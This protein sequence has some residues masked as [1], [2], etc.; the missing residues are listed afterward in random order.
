[1]RGRNVVLSG[2]GAVGYTVEVQVDG[3]VVGRI[4]ITSSTGAWTF[5]LPALAPGYREISTVN[6][7]SEVDRSAPSAP[8][9]VVIVAA[10]PLDFT[11]VGDTAITTWRRARNE[12]RVKTRRSSSGAWTTRTIAGRY[13]AIADYDDDGVSDV[14]AVGVRDGN[15]EWNVE[16]STTGKAVNV[17]V[18]AA[19]DTLVSGCNFAANKGASFAVFKSETRA[20]HFKSLGDSST[21]EVVLSGLGSCNVIGCGDTDGDGVDELLFTTRGA[22]NRTRVVGYD[23][24]GQRR[25]ES[26]YNSFVRGFVVDRP[27][28]TVPLVAVIGGTERRGRHVKITTMAGSFAFPRFFVERGA[29]IGNGTFTTETNEQVS[30]IFWADRKNRM[31]SRR[32]L[33]RGAETTEL[34]KLPRGFSLVRPQG[35][36]RTTKSER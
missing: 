27:N 19:G 23:T 18:G 32:L 15:L 11:G 33:S 36:V 21:R 13:P 20:L 4:P 7:A 22:D 29:T 6:V 14:A 35:I 16:L 1:V 3:I 24:T 30:G 17:S 10:A 5:T 28:S 8:V 9:K 34:F 26:K 31:V 25:F 12:V 2:T